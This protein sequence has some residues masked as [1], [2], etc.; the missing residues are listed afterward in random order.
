LEFSGVIK[1][2]SLV[3]AG[4]EDETGT[5]WLVIA[6]GLSVAGFAQEE[7][8]KSPDRIVSITLERIIDISPAKRML[9]CCFERLCTKSKESRCKK[10]Y[11]NRER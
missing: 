6:L 11:Q 4:V 9:H 7:K 3:A 2:F 5:A 8:S 1:Y 10:L